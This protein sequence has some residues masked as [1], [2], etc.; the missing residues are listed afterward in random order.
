MTIYDLLRFLVVTSRP[1]V[2][3]IEISLAYDHFK[4]AAL[5]L[6]DQLERTQALG[7]L[8]SELEGTILNVIRTH[9]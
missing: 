8:T 5:D 3:T 9:V 6:I 4:G 7:T 1:R 2:T